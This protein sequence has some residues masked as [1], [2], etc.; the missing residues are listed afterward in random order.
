M[1]RTRRSAGFVLLLVALGFTSIGCRSAR[2]EAAVAPDGPARRVADWF[3]DKHY[4]EADQ[5]ASVKAT[6]GEAREKVLEELRLAQGARAGGYQAS[7]AARQVYYEH[8]EGEGAH[9]V[10]ALRVDAG[11]ITLH[12]RVTLELAKV[13]GAWRVVR[14]SEEDLPGPAGGHATGPR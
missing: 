3:V 4:V 1:S 9:H 5:E 6:A 14:I 2:G 13:G 11:A 8:L 10:Y 12:K 7:R